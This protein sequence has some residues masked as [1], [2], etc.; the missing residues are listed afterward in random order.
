MAYIQETD[1]LCGIERREKSDAFGEIVVPVIILWK[2][3][4]GSIGAKRWPTGAT[5]G[6]DNVAGAL[7]HGDPVEVSQKKRK[8]GRTWFYVRNEEQDQEGWVLDALL[9]KLGKHAAEVRV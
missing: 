9:E 3:P 5:E 4:G 2:K 8:N 1:T 7:K 6:P